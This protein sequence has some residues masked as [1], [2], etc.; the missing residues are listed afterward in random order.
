MMTDERCIFFRVD[1]Q[2]G[3]GSNTWECSNCEDV[4]QFDEGSPGD[5][6]WSFC[7]ACGAAILDEI[8]EEDGE[9]ETDEEQ[10]E[11]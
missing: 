9:D 5:N 8:T 6:H 7:P 4:F 2:R 10:E 1:Y 3:E 11:D